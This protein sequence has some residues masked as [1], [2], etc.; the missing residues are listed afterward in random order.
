M[1]DELDRYVNALI[2]IQCICSVCLD[3]SGIMGKLNVQRIMDAAT[4]AFTPRNFTLSA[5]K[6]EDGLHGETI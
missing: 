2:K 6:F 1:S 4:E 3:G 5:P